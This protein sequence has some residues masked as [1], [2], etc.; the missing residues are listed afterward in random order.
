MSAENADDM[1]KESEDAIKSKKATYEIQEIISKSSSAFV[2]HVLRLED[3]RDLAMKCESVKVK[4]PTLRHEARVYD[5]LKNLV[6][7]HFVAFE[8]RGLVDERFVFFVMRMVGKNLFDLRRDVP[9]HKFSMGTAIRIA[10][11]TLTAIR[12]LHICGYIHRDIKP[13]NFAIGREEDDSYHTVFILDFKFARKFRAEG[14]DLRLEREKAAFRGTPRYASITAL[15]M[16][17]QSRKDDIESWWY[18]IVELM[19][20]QLPWQDMQPDQIEEILHMKK[21]VRLPK[22]LKIF[23]QGTPQEYMGNIIQY[24]DTLQ[25]NSIPDYDHIAAQLST[26]IK[27]HYLN[28]DAP[29]DWDLMTKYK[30]PKYE[31]V[32]LEVL[33]KG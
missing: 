18:M 11:Q 24:V 14:K 30:G 28:W 9:D 13:D 3:K 8:D 2:F 4:V 22:N 10:E 33:Q 20:G 23:L 19:V 16:K 12:D 21:K 29:P 5:A 7:P 15:S 32:D 31:K 27:A 25:Y 17:E 1:P 6:S 26:A